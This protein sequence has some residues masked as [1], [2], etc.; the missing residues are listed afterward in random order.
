MRRSWTRAAF[1]IAALA[2]L[3]LVLLDDQAS[4]GRSTGETVTPVTAVALPDLPGKK[5]TAVVVDYAPDA[6]SAAH[7]HGGSVFAFVLEGAVRSRLDDGEAKVY[8]A[9]ESFFEPPGTHHVVS[10][11]VSADAP[12]RLL[13]VI[14][15]D[16]AATLTTYD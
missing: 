4:L 9:G 14:I 2:G 8:R 1:G 11:N 6:R 15:T 16:E 7:R 3:G 12:A 13:A 5:L 10:E